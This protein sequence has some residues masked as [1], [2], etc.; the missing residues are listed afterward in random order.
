MGSEMVQKGFRRGSRFRRFREVQAWFADHAETAR[1]GRCPGSQPLRQPTVLE[2]KTA[3]LPR[4]LLGTLP[5]IDCGMAGVG[6]FEDLF[7]WQLSVELRDRILD[8]TRNGPA[9]RD[10]DFRNDIRRSARSAPNNLSEGFGAFYPREFAR[11]GRIARRSIIETRNHLLD[12]CTQKYFSEDD[13]RKL[14]HLTFRAQKATTGLIKYLDSCRGR[15]P[16]GWDF[17]Q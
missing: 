13:L 5:A 11:F 2:I 10:V 12:A 16:A 17:K 15:P 9:A 1:V 3:G 6:R 8:L 14:I 4:R 7:A